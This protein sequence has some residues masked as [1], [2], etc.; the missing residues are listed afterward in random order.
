MMPSGFIETVPAVKARPG[1]GI[2]LDS[3]GQPE[4]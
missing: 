1:K 4:K 3:A 2:W